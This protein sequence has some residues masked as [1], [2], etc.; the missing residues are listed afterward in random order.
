MKTLYKDT[1]TTM[2][3]IQVIGKTKTQTTAMETQLN[4]CYCEDSVYFLLD[5][6]ICLNKVF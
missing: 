5:S 4:A 6:S 1:I 3:L 2:E